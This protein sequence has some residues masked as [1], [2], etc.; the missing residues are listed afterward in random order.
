MSELEQTTDDAV[1]N[2]SSPSEPMVTVNNKTV[3]ISQAE[4]VIKEME[5]SIKSGFEKKLTEE[6]AS[7]ANAL[8]EDTSF[9]RD[10]AD[11]PDLW[12]H[13]EPKVGGGRGFVGDEK[14]LSESPSQTKP[15]QN[16]A[17]SQQ[18][19]F[20]DQTKLSKIERELTSVKE[21]LNAVV[22]YNDE[23][24][25]KAVVKTLDICNTKYPAADIDGVKAQLQVYYNAN[26]Q[27]HAA[28]EVVEEMVKNSH[29]R[30]S[31][32]FNLDTGTTTPESAT[33]SPKG[34]KAPAPPNPKIPNMFTDPEGFS[35]WQADQ[36]GKVS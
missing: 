28:P 4:Q 5:S 35:E 34:G 13:Y 9:Y 16:Q 20:G 23:A 24:A 32:K 25:R 3:P 15:N 1:G 33:P 17:Q 14:L 10:H 26:G 11:R 22:G 7:L 6:R 18:Q 19:A 8:E 30:M 21:K 36:F 27:H 2:D 31:K 29:E 12:E